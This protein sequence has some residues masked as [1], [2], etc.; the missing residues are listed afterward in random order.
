MKKTISLLLALVLALSL[1]ACSKKA[2]TDSSAASTAESISESAAESVSESV[3][4][5]ES[6]AES[7]AADTTLTITD[8]TFKV[9][10]GF[11]A[12]ES[13]ADMYY[14]PDYPNDS[15]NIYVASGD[16]DPNF[17]KYTADIL[18]TGL[19]SSLTQQLGENIDITIDSFDYTTID[20]LPAYRLVM[21]YTYSDTL[22]TQLQI[23]VNADKSYS[24]TYTQAGDADWMEAFDTSAATIHFE[25]A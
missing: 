17:E 8:Y 6:A 1:A 19:E 2:G 13:N 24:F 25:V 11:T 14:A 3:A 10:D 18:E 4:E 15:S 12:D 9:P 7:T 5:S 21:H 16:S 20:D 22:I 23:G